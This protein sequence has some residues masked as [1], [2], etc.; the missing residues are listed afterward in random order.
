M[1][2]QSLPDRIFVVF[3]DHLCGAKET[4]KFIMIKAKARLVLWVDGRVEGRY[5]VVVG[6]IL[7]EL[8]FDSAGVG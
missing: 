3:L 6:D 7:I 5:E 8:L 1:R 4:T 2:V